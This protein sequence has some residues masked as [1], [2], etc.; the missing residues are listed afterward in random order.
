MGALGGTKPGEA[1]GVSAMGNPMGLM[2]P[3][4]EWGVIGERWGVNREDRGKGDM[5]LSDVSS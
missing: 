4:V 5:S 3:G 2:R 1:V